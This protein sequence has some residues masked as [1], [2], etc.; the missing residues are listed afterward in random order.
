MERDDGGTDEII[1]EVEQRRA[2]IVERIDQLKTRR[3]EIQGRG[4]RGSTPV[5]VAAAARHAQVAQQNAAQ[6][7][8]R[9]GERH[10]HAARAHDR[11]AERFEAIGEMAMARKHR[12][13]AEGMRRAAAEDRR[14]A[15]AEVRA[16]VR[17]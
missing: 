16:P 2:Q 6:A 9:A 11:A 12:A 8:R 13:A 15:S 4:L 17:R 3:R 1:A 14:K 10:E 5:D 7:H